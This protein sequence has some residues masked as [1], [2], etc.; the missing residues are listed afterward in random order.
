MPNMR[1]DEFRSAVN[2]IER[3]AEREI[4][5]VKL[6]SIF[7]DRGVLSSLTLNTNQPYPWA[8][9]G[10]KNAFGSVFP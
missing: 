5:P 1:S 4:D 3:R 10:G 2:D 8:A 7:V 6:A 9:R